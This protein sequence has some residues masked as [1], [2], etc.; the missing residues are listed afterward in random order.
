MARPVIK[1]SQGSRQ[2]QS[3]QA[4]TALLQQQ[5]APVFLKNERLSKLRGA[6]DGHKYQHTYTGEIPGTY[7]FLLFIGCLVD[8]WWFDWKQGSCFK[9][10]GISFLQVKQ[11]NQAGTIPRD[12]KHDTI[13]RD[14]KLLPS[15]A[16]SRR[17]HFTAPNPQLFRSFYF[18]FCNA[19]KS[20]NGGGVNMDVPLR[21]DH[22]LSDSQYFGS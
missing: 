20:L 16:K 10:L 12:L 15:N 17:Q 1:M 8:W 4:E 2:I 22:S 7:S 5:G 18:H 14:L 11:S 6:G 21:A 3:Q 13:P 19:L 9:C